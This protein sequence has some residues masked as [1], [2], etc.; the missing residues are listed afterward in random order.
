M[1]RKTPKSTPQHAQ[2]T[3]KTPQT[4][5][6]AI[7]NKYQYITMSSGGFPLTYIVW[8]VSRSYSARAPE[9]PDE[10]KDFRPR[11]ADDVRFEIVCYHGFRYT[12]AR[13]P[14]SCACSSQGRARRADGRA[15]AGARE[16]SRDGVEEYEADGDCTRDGAA[17]D[18]RGV[19]GEVQ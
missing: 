18:E 4:D 11:A 9:V 19:P 13:S 5:P 15:G 6:K 16:A 8:F 17:A 2:K 12:A 3:R 1:S 14:C 7:V 10:N